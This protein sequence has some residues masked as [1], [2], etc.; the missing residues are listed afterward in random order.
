MQTL[1]LGPNS[2]RSKYGCCLGIQLASIVELLP[3]DWEWY[4]ADVDPV[5]DTDLSESSVS[6]V[7]S[8]AD[9]VQQVSR[10]DQLESGVFLAVANAGGPPR[11]RSEVLTD[12]PLDS[13][14]GD[15]LLEIRAFDTSYFDVIVRDRH[16]LRRLLDRYDVEPN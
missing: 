12:D 16:C 15:A 4:S 5:N 2:F 6:L 7:G 3:G 1:R 9:L 13:D 11:F 8:S 10:I 14:I